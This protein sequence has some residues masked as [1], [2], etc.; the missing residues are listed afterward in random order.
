MRTDN[1]ETKNK[2]HT[3]LYGVATYAH[4]TKIS[5]NNHRHGNPTFAF[6]AFSLS[7]PSPCLSDELTSTA[8]PLSFSLFPGVLRCCFH[9]LRVPCPSFLSFLQYPP[10]IRFRANLSFLL[11]QFPLFRSRV[12]NFSS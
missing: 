9:Y 4:I 5:Q 3:T 1:F 8:V 10:H 6:T 7:R 11:R 2:N 12:S